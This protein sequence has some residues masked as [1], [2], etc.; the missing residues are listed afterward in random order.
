MNNRQTRCEL[1][2]VCAVALCTRLSSVWRMR[3]LPRVAPLGVSHNPGFPGIS[4]SG[5]LRVLCPGTQRWGVLLE[6][7]PHGPNRSLSSRSEA[8]CSVSLGL[9]CLP[10]S[11]R[12]PA[13]HLT[14]AS[15]CAIHSR[16]STPTPNSDD[17]P[18]GRG[19][20]HHSRAQQ[21]RER[22][23]MRARSA[24]PWPSQGSAF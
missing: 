11:Q 1:Y 12:V 2:C 24:S 16:L 8:G 17:L 23:P 21:Q 10:I 3:L 4:P 20:G 22:K 15:P 7:Y 19:H 6:A 5:P 13:L 9:M 14:S 18:S